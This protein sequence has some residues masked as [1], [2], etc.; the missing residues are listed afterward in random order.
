MCFSIFKLD[1]LIFETHFWNYLLEKKLLK[2]IESSSSQRTYIQPKSFKNYRNLNRKESSSFKKWLGKQLA[3][4]ETTNWSR[5]WTTTVITT[6]IMT[7]LQLHTT[8]MVNQSRWQIVSKIFHQI[9]ISLSK[10]QLNNF[11]LYLKRSHFNRCTMQG[12]PGQFER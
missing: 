5:T 11:C 6:T 4:T 7:T 12:M 2:I 8:T 1:I 9:Y 10:D 3:T